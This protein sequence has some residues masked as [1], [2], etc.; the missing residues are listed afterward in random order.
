MKYRTVRR[1]DSRGRRYYVDRATGKR[2]SK[3]EYVRDHDPDMLG[4]LY[5][6]LAVMILAQSAKVLKRQE[7][8]KK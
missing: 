3:R 7:R 1:T 8:K 4:L 5:D 2:V 6:L